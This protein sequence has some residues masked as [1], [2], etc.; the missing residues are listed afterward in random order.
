MFCKKCGTKLS[1]T[2]KFCKV[3]GAKVANVS[4]PQESSFSHDIATG[5]EFS[6]GKKKRRGRKIIVFIFCIIILTGATLCIYIKYFSNKRLITNLNKTYPTS[7]AVQTGSAEQV[8]SSAATVSAETPSPTEDSD[9]MLGMITDIV[10]QSKLDKSISFDVSWNEVKE[11][12]SYEI[13][14]YIKPYETSQDYEFYN[15]YRVRNNFFSFDTCRNVVYGVKVCIKSLQTDENGKESYG[16]EGQSS[17]TNVFSSVEEN[18]KNEKYNQEQDDLTEE[19][20]EG[21]SEYIFQNSDKEYLTQ[22]DIKGMTRKK[23]NLAKNE[24]YARHGYIFKKGGDVRKYFESKSWY[25]P[26]V[27]GVEFE[28]NGDGYYFN[29]Y[30]I[31]NR[32]MLVK[33]DKKLKK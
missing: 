8:T 19:E 1:E 14:T 2:A 26:S 10:I 29:K 9:E 11:A 3:C 30:E 28:K 7:P 27:S 21:D 32:N 17:I 15:V 31:A 6:G 24:L 18:V 12:D 20:E 4:H 22:K 23:I 5:T 16:I 33:Y 13:N 25:H